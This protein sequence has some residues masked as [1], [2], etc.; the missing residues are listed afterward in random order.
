MIHRKITVKGKVQGVY[1]R[2][3]ARSIAVK[4]GLKGAVKNLPDGNVWI[5]AE[6]PETAVREFIDWCRIGPTGAV[7]T[8][9]DITE[10]TPEN[11]QQFDILHE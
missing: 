6:G 8:S 11:Y 9:L 3:T 5:A 10:G 2:A 1:F 7:V 4:L